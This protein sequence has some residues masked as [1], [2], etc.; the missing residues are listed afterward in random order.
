MNECYLDKSVIQL[1]LFVPVVV[2]FREIGSTG[3]FS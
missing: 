3:H 1:C 2:Y